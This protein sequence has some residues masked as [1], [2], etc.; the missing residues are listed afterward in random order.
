[1]S[2]TAEA[3]VVGGWTAYHP[4]TAEDR[5]V[6]D[7]AMEGFVGVTYT[8]NEVSTQVV[9]GTN[10]RYRC[11][12]SMPPAMVVWQAIV[13]IYQPLDGKPYITDIHRI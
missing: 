2:Q 3:T 11:T 13:Q 5:K 7:E 6:F 9:A 4:L 1:M 12:A 8:P 10:Y